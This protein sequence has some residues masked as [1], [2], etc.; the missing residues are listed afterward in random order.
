MFGLRKI[1]AIIASALLIIALATTYYESQLKVISDFSLS[2]SSEKQTVTQG[3]STQILV[4]VTHL[5][6][7]NVNVTLNAN[8]NSSSIQYS[9]MSASGI[10]NFTTALTV[11]TSISTPTSYCQINVTANNGQFNHTAS[12]TFGVLSSRVFVSGIMTGNHINSP[13]TVT[14]INLTFVDLSTGLA[15]ES[16]VDLGNFYVHYDVPTG[17]SGNYSV[18]LF[19]GHT[20]NVTFYETTVENDFP[21]IPPETGGNFLGNFTVSA[22]VGNTTQSANFYGGWL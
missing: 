15:Y 12:F 16:P 17:G 10:P 21:F 7:K 4:N 1:L 8:S 20:Y 3:E 11:T 13:L 9:L 2:L 18:V 14:P 6:G 22:P 19:N 5:S